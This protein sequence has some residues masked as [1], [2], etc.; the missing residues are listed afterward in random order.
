M[1]KTRT[2]AFIWLVIIGALSL[3]ETAALAGDYLWCHTGGP[4]IGV[5]SLPIQ[6]DGTRSSGGQVVLVSYEWLFG[7]GSTGEGALVE[8]TY[9]TSDIYTITLTTRDYDGASYVC[10]SVAS[11][12]AGCET[13]ICDAGGPYEGD[14]GERVLFDGTGSCL[15]S[16]LIVSYEWS[17]GDGATGTGPRVLHEYH[18]AGVFTV[19]IVVADGQGAT[20]EC[21]TTATVAPSSTELGTW[22]HVKRWFTRLA[23]WVGRSGP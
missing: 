2:A 9:D 4:Y 18:E 22:G 13:P 6:F 15:P 23:G 20:S 10:S 7:D 11:V 3:L 14:L 1:R 21:T 16:A 17:F 19:G 8:H 5:E 12:V